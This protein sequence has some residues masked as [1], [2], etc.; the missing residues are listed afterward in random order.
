[1]EIQ[2]DEGRRQADS[3]VDRLSELRELTAGAD[4]AAAGRGQ[5]FSIAGEPGIGKSRLADEAARYAVAH[6]AEALWGRCWEGGGA[7]A[8]WPWIQIFRGL[9]NDAD[10]ASIQKWLGVGAAEIAQI[11]PELRDLLSHVP[12]LSVGS[13]GTSE[14]ARFRLFDS[15]VSFLRRAAESRPLVIVL[16]DLHAADTTSL[17]ML[18]AIAKSIR[19][20]RALVIGTY[21]QAEIRQSPE[22]AALIAEAE[23]EGTVLP[24]HGLRANEIGEF[25]ERSTGISP[26]ASLVSLL[27]QKTDG[28]PFFLSEV[29]RL[30]AAEG[31]LLDGGGLAASGQLRIP[32]GVRESIKRR[33]A[34]LGDR[35]RDLL[36]I[37][38]VIGRE[39]DVSCLERCGGVSRQAMIEL[40]DK[41]V[42]LELLG[43]IAEAPGRYSF[44]HA[45]IR[46]AIYSDLPS[47]RRRRLHGLVGSAIRDTYVA[48]R[49]SAELAYHYCEA[50]L[51]GDADMA[52]EYS[53][54]AARE[55]EKQL[56]FEQASRHLNRAL[57]V[58][59]L[60]RDKSE[61]LHA[62]LMLELGQSQ[63]KARELSAGRQACL[64]GAEIA[65][66]VG[67][68]EL[69]A[70]AIVAAGRPISNSGTTDRELVVLLREALQ[71]LGD[72]DSAVRAQVLA[73]LGLEL[74]WSQREESAALC[75]RAFNMAQRVGD[76]HTYIVSLWARHLS[77]RAPDGLEQRLADSADLITTA[78][79]A[80]EKD[81]A[82]EARFYR[83][84]DLLE[85]GDIA[86]AD[87]EQRDYLKAEGEFRDC[88]RRGLLLEGMRAQLDGRLT[89]G[90]TLAQQA[91]AIGQQTQR[92]LA[93]N[94][95]LVQM[96]NILW[97]RGRLGELSDTLKGFIAENPL[98]V[99][100]RC[101]LLLC[102]IQQ[103][104]QPEA[105][106]ELDKLAEDQFS[107]IPRDWNWLPSMF[108]L[109]VVCAELSAVEHAPG[110]YDLLGPYHSRNAVLGNVYCYGSISYG[111]G[112]LAATLGQLD[113]AEAHFEAALTANERIRATVWLAHTQCELSAVLRDRGRANDHS[114]ALELFAS[115]SRTAQSLKLVRLQN[116]LDTIR[117]GGIALDLPSSLQ[118]ATVEHAAQGLPRAVGPQGSSLD[119]V[120]AAAISDP[121]DLHSYSAL[122]STLTIMFSD[123]EDSSVIFERL[124]DLRA[125]ELVRRHNKIIREQ[126][127]FHSGLEVKSTGDGF[128]VVFS[129]ARRALLCA[130]AIQR[131]LAAYPSACAELPV[132]VRIGLHVGEAIKES[133]DF[134]GKAVILAA[135]M[136]AL[137]DG[138]E[139]VVSSMLRE[140]T[141]SAGDITFS[142]GKEVRL[143]GFSGTYHIYYVAW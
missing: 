46:E 49:H 131:A 86:Q 45:L 57:E 70:R 125:Q 51:T 96:G 130:I 100:A 82:L 67:Q 11:M 32:D 30:M 129:S 35:A 52:V 71:L 93:L 48:E 139:I 53:R 17:M 31:R 72:I 9:M 80:G 10:A 141:A 116:K 22:R 6:G 5:L 54:R 34:P 127:S 84:A 69:F 133:A 65:R 74:Y 62:E 59:P 4:Q 43:E 18:T 83:I 106:R 79:Q 13:L 143:K 81:F 112:R 66:R 97:E 56:A 37:A 105:R 119:A 103:A 15:A 98:I 101:G 47:T 102:L 77:L 3:F 40:L 121:G 29:L 108:V 123:I 2:S 91:F 64:Q 39:F 27:D 117:S 126:V 85:L 25:V 60:T 99:F 113:Q 120:A 20:I 109:A 142:D 16:D 111:L 87:I 58:L 50:A 90:E 124:G 95:F 21:R 24:L 33:I 44:H 115:A 78:E 28:N 14:Q 42:A 137:A 23:R 136:A 107:A 104:R 134:F 138:G 89:E 118:A 135:R 92:P 110:L 26:T 114:R 38:A 36:S 73:R 61:L 55:A 7:P 122:G 1:M 88:F 63:I 68:T 12:E 41:A 94:S 132:R 19:T 75:Q 128:M 76:P 8:Y 140:L